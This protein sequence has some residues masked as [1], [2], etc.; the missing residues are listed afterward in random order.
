MKA[1]KTLII[2]LGT[3]GQNICEGIAK[4]LNS[5]YGDYKK[6]PWVGIR[7]LETAHKSDVLDKNDFIQLSVDT[8]AFGDYIS[9]APHVGSGFGWNDWGDPALL[10]NV[11]S[12][13]NVGAGNIRMA[14][15][16]AL[17]HNYAYVSGNITAEIDRIA[18][19]TPAEIQKCLDTKESIDIM[20]GA[21]NIY[22][23]GSLCGGTGSG[24]CADM[25]YLVRIWGNNNVIPI[26]IF[27]LPHWSLQA[28]RLKKNAFMALTEINHYMLDNFAWQQKLPGFAN[29]ATDMRRPYDIA[30]LTQPSTAMP[31]EI[32]KNEY[33]IA[34]FLSAVCS[35]TS[36]D[37]AAAN[38]DGINAL[39]TNRELGY[40]RPSFSTFGTAVLEY[41]GEHMS[42]LCKE[43]LLNRFYADWAD[44]PS[45]DISALRAEL[46][47][48]SPKAIA[49]RLS[50]QKI[51]D[52]YVALMQAELDK[53]SANNG[54]KR[55]SSLHS[56]LDII[57]STVERAAKDDAEIASRAE[58]WIKNFTGNLEDRFIK[59]AE[60]TLCTFEGGPGFLSRALQRSKADIE[61]WSSPKGDIDKFLMSANTALENDKKNVRK[62]TEDYLKINGLFCGNKRKEAWAE[63]QERLKNCAKSC[64]K[65]AVAAR[66]KDLSDNTV[67]GSETIME[68]FNLFSSRY[69][70]R[71][72]NFESAIIALRDAHDAIYRKN[73]NILPPINGK[74]FYKN[75]NPSDETDD[76]YAKI[77]ES[78]DNNPNSSFEK[79]EKDTAAKIFEQIKTDAFQRIQSSVSC[80]DTKVLAEQSL[81]IPEDLKKNA[82]IKAGAFFADF[83]KYRHIIYEIRNNA[84]AEI[85]MLQLKAEP[86]LKTSTAPIPAKFQNDPVIGNISVTDYNYAFCPLRPCGYLASQE[87]ID[88]VRNLL[89]SVQLRK[90]VFDN[91]DSYRIMAIKMCHGTSLAH[92]NGIL[93]TNDSDM[94]A[95]E[96]AMSC[97]DF[98]FWNT[99]KDVR[100]TNCLIS[101]ESIDKIKQ[102]WLVYRLLGY[103]RTPEGE[104]LMKAEDGSPKPWYE[105]TQGKVAVEILSGSV[106]VR[107]ERVDL[108]FNSAISDIAFKNMQKMMEATCQN[109]IK[110]YMASAGKAGIVKTLFECLESID[111]YFL[112]IKKEE[113]EKIIISY[114]AA[115]GLEAEYINYKFPK[116]APID[117]S[118]FSQ[119]YRIDGP[120][121]EGYYCPHGH[122]IGGGDIQASLRSMIQNRFKCPA[123]PT[124]E[125]YWPY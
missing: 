119:L 60:R 75:N 107:K 43:R 108:D 57:I 2:G 81:Y 25:G 87:E 47:E 36:H 38:V 94:Q 110:T 111:S 88:N 115:N 20:S 7:V 68:K 52:K 4:N 66:L 100:W 35:E 21:V 99:R 118:Q 29:A 120:L 17:Y 103:H 39:A 16:L 78:L 91:G 24:C 56:K 6:A 34:S 76:I 106:V 67:S 1:A 5:K 73:L 23:V 97:A 58:S 77:I 71:L 8:S 62:Q 10:R 93:K 63:T 117:P 74:Q 26:G 95:L 9:G 51:T 50:D 49:E 48:Q 55:D 22:I 45:K 59:M 15:R 61:A 79:K 114:C 72:D 89:G 70:S 102:F 98:N 30:Y 46:F 104:F 82:E 3:S 112:N 65:A 27:T 105:L 92:I 41:P 80:F 85:K 11:G 101:K 86:T 64:V 109:R 33:A 42:R 54:L 19:I 40:L 96:D 124:G 53:A 121:G 113:A 83:S 122:K 37:I 32:T 13:I 12:C 123:C 116:D 31:D 14:G 44:S 84:P 90:P 125:P 18:K 69:I 28:Q